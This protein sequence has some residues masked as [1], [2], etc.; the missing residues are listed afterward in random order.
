MT[1]MLSCGMNGY[2]GEWCN[3][4]GVPAKSG[5]AGGIII[6]VP[7]VCPAV[8]CS[9]PCCAMWKWW[10]NCVL[11]SCMCVRG[12]TRVRLSARGHVVSLLP[13]AVIEASAAS[14]GG[15]ACLCVRVNE[16]WQVMGIA[17][18]SP[19]LNEYFNSLRGTAFCHQLFARYPCGVF[20]NI[21]RRKLTDVEHTDSPMSVT[22]TVDSE[23]ESESAVRQ[24]SDRVCVPCRCLADVSH[25]SDYHTLPLVCPGGKRTSVAVGAR[26]RYCR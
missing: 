19:P 26:C 23:A 18:F 4:T 3:S 1:L 20:D 17:V 14:C 21:F 5:V 8:E 15:C 9:V 25:A 7:N 22:S 16:P 6:V 13:C 10:R 12:R 24:S 2:S 11:A